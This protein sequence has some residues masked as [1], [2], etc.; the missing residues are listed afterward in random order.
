LKL[1]LLFYSPNDLQFFHHRGAKSTK[2]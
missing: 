1:N 2:L